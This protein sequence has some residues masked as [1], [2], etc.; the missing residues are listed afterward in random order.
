[1][2]TLVLVGRS[3]GAACAGGVSA[4]A[5]FGLLLAI[6]WLPTFSA[7]TAYKATTTLLAAAAG[8][9]IGGYMAGLLAGR[10]QAL[11]GGLFGLALGLFA[12]AYVLGPA[13]YALIAA[14]LA[15]LFGALGG[16]SVRRSTWAQ[17]A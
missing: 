16:W 8:F 4:L 13:W 3:I 12:F 1:M 14:G 5:G 9:F 11:H 7:N 6:T 15:G 10:R 17:E 2:K